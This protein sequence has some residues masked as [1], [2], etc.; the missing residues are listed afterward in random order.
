MFKL[1]TN[2]IRNNDQ[3]ISQLNLDEV[4]PTDQWNLDQFLNE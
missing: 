4:Q 2:E 3:T 1:L